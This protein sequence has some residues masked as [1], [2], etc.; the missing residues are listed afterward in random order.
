MD[1][2]SG[3]FW[4]CLLSSLQ[5]TL[6]LRI[7]SL[8]NEGQS[9]LWSTLSFGSMK[10]TLIKRIVLQKPLLENDRIETSNESVY[11]SIILHMNSTL[12]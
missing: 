7:L 4:G 9:Q 6:T 12:I 2:I 5:L 11:I 3:K 1:P 10:C 8:S